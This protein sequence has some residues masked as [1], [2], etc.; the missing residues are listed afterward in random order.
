MDTRETTCLIV[1]D[2]PDAGWALEHILR[3]SAIRLERALTAME[4]LERMRGRTFSLAFLDVKLPDLDGLELA[5]RIRAIDPL[6][7]IILISGYYYKDAAAIQQAQAEGLIHDFIGKPFLH[8]ELM[9]AVARALPPRRIRRSHGGANPRLC[10]AG[11]RE[12]IP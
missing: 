9:R 11:A 1:D 5:R 6:L 10:G 2:E 4:A 8:A 3:P 12:P 7:P